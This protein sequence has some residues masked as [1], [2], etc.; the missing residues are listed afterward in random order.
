MLYYII[1][2]PPSRF[3][4][5]RYVYA[6]RAQGKAKPIALPGAVVLCP[7]LMRLLEPIGSPRTGLASDF[8]GRLKLASVL[9]ECS[10]EGVS[11]FCNT[12]QDSRSL[13]V[14]SLFWN[15]IV[16]AAVFPVRLICSRRWRYLW[17]Q[18]LLSL[19]VDRRAYRLHGRWLS[20][21]PKF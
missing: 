6:L 17:T 8:Q 4:I 2:K 20:L 18:T 11:A 16:E 3:L 21:G 10:T 19:G 13:V 1:G 15:L 12:G 5:R 14:T 7:S 9:A